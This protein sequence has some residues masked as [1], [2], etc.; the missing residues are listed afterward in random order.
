[1]ANETLTR[2]TGTVVELHPKSS[3]AWCRAK[4]RKYDGTHTWVTGKFGLEI[5]EVLDADCTFNQ[6]YK[7]HDV[8]SFADTK[9]TV[10]NQ[11]VILKLVETL[12][13]VGKVK[14]AKLSEHF[15][16]L[17]RAVTET[18]N[19]V[20]DFVGVDETDVRL[21]ASNLEVEKSKLVGVSALVNRGYP[22]HLAK[23]IANTPRAYKAAMESPYKAI[24]LVEGLGWLIADEVGRKWGIQLDDPDRIK[25]GIDHYYRTKVTSDGHTRVRRSSLLYPEA[26]PSLLGVGAAKI[27]EQIDN[28]L[29]A[30]FD[31]PHYTDAIKT[32]AQLEDGYWY[33]SEW[34]LKNAQTIAGFFLR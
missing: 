20:A 26:L 21:V 15:P 25:A 30:V 9:G 10:A 13:G 18:P 27:L 23:R 31:P 5:G 2:I 12:P 7:S 14:A 6:T 4:V 34:H 28:V 11:V 22:H 8:V 19:L 29:I 16:E 17:F 32:D 24:K 33:T 3:E 1:M